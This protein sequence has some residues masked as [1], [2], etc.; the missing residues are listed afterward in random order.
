MALLILGLGS[1]I[2]DRAAHLAAA[3][4]ELRAI[5]AAPRASRAYESRA[6]L[7]E[8]APAEWDMP[9]LNMAV[10]G[11]CELAPQE[12]LQRVKAIEQS[13]GREH[14]GYWG[15]REIDVDIL[16]FGDIVLEGPELTIPHREL[17][18]RDFALLPL[19]DVAPEWRYPTGE[20]RGKTAAEIVKLM[21]FQ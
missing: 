15:P 2:G 5:L 8:G 19:C 13:L 7:P 20:Y 4:A 17:L 1:N 14:R 3:Q 6:V 21:G 11:E 12:V 9:Y 16:A 10:A 18:K